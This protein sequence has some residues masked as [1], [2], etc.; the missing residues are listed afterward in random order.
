[1]LQSSS[2]RWWQVLNCKCGLWWDVQSCGETHDHLRGSHHCS[3]QILAHIHQ[4]DVQNVFLYG[5]LHEIVYMHQL[6]NFCDPLHF[7]HICR[8]KKSLYGLKQVPLSWYQH[9]VDYVS[10]IRF[11]HSVSDYSFFIYRHGSD[12][13]Y[14]LLCWSHHSHHLLTWPWQ[15]YHGTP[16]LWICYEGS[17][18]F[19]LFFRD[20]CDKT[21]KWLVP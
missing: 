3:L 14:I 19:E 6:F 8:L 13:P 20:C 1:M 15:I 10:T 2:C 9:F 16:C 11:Q 7:D 21:C 17:W 12:M 4:L 18:L 5:D